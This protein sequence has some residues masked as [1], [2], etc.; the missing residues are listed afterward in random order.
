MRRATLSAD[1]EACSPSFC[2]DTVVIQTVSK[3]TTLAF[4]N[5][6]PGLGHGTR[7]IPFVWSVRVFGVTSARHEAYGVNPHFLFLNRLELMIC[8]SVDG[9]TT[10]GRRSCLD[11]LKY[12]ELLHIRQG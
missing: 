10:R 3:T 6:T 5:R 8:L 4:G 2:N 7:A 11:S 1:L 12:S 9:S